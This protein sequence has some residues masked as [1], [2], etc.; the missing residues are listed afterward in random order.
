MPSNSS[1]ALRSALLNRAWIQ[2]AAL[3]VDA[4]VEEDD[5]VVDLEALIALT[6][7]LGDA[8]VRLLDVS[9][10]WCVSFG[11]YVNGARLRQVA[12]ELASPQGTLGEFVA[13][14]AV[15]GGPA[16][17]LATHPRPG[18]VRRSKARLESAAS[19]A[20][21][22]V[23]LRAAFGVNARADLLAA[24]LSA[25]ESWFSVADLSRR[26]RFT[27]PNLV[28][29]VDALT[30]AGLVTSR[31]IANERRVRL[32]TDTPL[33]PGLQSPIPQ[34]DW[35][36]RFGVSLTV[37]R[38]LDQ[39]WPTPIVRAI[40]ARRVVEPLLDTIGSERMP[41]PR[42]DAFGES[43]SFAFDRWVADLGMWLRQPSA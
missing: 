18:Y 2:W 38:H 33:L 30:L 13:T 19:N 34:S 24:M 41:Q 8:D 11:R 15:A 40:E 22:N 6:A 36:A 3:G 12:R 21:L 29:A 43:F 35:V 9:T 17:P 1:S 4:V 32:V 31:T 39:E 16:W 5:A 20:R 27:K 26:T 42:L 10:D 25:P 37:L 14:V 23:R 7:E 28:S